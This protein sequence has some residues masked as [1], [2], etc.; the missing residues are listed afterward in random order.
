MSGDPEAIRRVLLVLLDNAIKY[1]P[2]GGEIEVRMHT[3]DSVAHGAAI[4]EVRDTG[5]GIQAQHVPRIFDRFYRVAADRSRKTGG[6]GLGLTSAQAVIR[7][8]G[9]EISLRNRTT[10][11]LEVEVILPVLS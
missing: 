10:G 3:V 5:P 1:T 6:A 4:I 11:G 2:A 9:G 7:G 8:H